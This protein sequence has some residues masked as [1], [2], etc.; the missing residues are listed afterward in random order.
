M[1]SQSVSLL[2]DHL[3]GLLVDW[4]EPSV[5]LFALQLARHNHTYPYTKYRDSYTQ[6]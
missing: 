6:V 1:V 2:L 4:L 5:I 3:V